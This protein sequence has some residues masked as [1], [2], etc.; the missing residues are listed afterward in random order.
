MRP[1]LLDTRLEAEDALLPFPD[2]EAMGRSS[3]NFNNC[4]ISLTDFNGVLMT[5]KVIK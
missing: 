5:A 2:V 1:E 4:G 3:S